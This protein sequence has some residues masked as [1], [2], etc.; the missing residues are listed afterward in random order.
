MNDDFDILISSLIQ[1]FTK[2]LNL[3]TQRKDNYTEKSQLKDFA[4]RLPKG[5]GGL[6]TGLKL[7]VA[8]GGLAYGLA[9]SVY[10]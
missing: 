4:S 2:L 3:A 10:T 6:G 5:G 7:L 9:Q 1:I 8:A